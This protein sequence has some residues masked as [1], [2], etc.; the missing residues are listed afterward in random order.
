MTM[1]R[2]YSELLKIT[3]N[4]SEITQKLLF[5]SNLGKKVTG[6]IKETQ[7]SRSVAPLSFS[8]QQQSGIHLQDRRNNAHKLKIPAASAGDRSDRLS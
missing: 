3:Q 4:Y 5:A 7:K 8:I 2:N 6:I 1:N